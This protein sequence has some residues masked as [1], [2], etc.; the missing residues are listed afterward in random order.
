M[1]TQEGSIVLVRDCM[2][3]D[4]VTASPHT[5]VL[6][7]RGL[8]AAHTIR[9]LPV[10]DT[11]RL[12]GMVSDR[13]VRVE[14]S[15]DRTL[16]GL[17]SDLIAG[18]YRR[19]ETVMSSPV[20]TVSPTTSVA[21][22]AQMMLQRRVGAL[23]VVDDGALAGILGLTDCV[24][25]L[26]DSPPI[27]PPRDDDIDAVAMPPGDTRPG[28][29]TRRRAVVVVDSDPRARMRTSDALRTAGYAVVTCPGPEAGVFCPAA[30][31]SEQRCSRVPAEIEQ[32]FI[33]AA[34]AAVAVA[35]SYH[36]WVPSAS[37]GVSLAPATSAKETR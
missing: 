35:D 18:R 24:R 25:S 7:A 37:V 2:T 3:R 6:N 23:P 21:V 26:L 30:R 33:A 20:Y 28:R 5:S 36:R 12:V 34:P 16:A 27:A 31:G 13:D 15:L 8:L 4:V 17:Q 29:P 9:H 14:A 1:T 19:V 22:A 32:V 11:G 10:V